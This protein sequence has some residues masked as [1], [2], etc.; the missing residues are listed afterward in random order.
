MRIRRR[1]SAPDGGFAE[2]GESP[3]PPP[4]D[5]P[6]QA[7][8]YAGLDAASRGMLLPPPRPDVLPEAVA[9]R[10]HRYVRRPVGRHMALLFGV[11]LLGVGIGL[12]TTIG[13]SHQVLIR[14]RLFTGNSPASF[15]VA[16]IFVHNALVAAVPLLLFPILFW[17]PAA[18]MGVT[19]FAVG[20]L[21]GLWQTLH[22]PNGALVLAL[23]PHGL[24]EIPSF[25][26]AGTFAWRIGW[27]SWDGGHFGGSWWTRVRSSVL[28]A[29]PFLAGVIAA[30]AVAATIEVK[31]TPAI[32]RS[33]YPNI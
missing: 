16:G 1:S 30:L 18:S 2:H 9:S 22:L 8:R 25:L 4:P 31:V 27:A 33:I 32:L 24:I 13:Q 11:L 26:V 14:D 3:P 10:V 15:T 21:A 6:D 5:R 12:G 7:S 20:R 23:V 17:G 19:G 29:L 28:A